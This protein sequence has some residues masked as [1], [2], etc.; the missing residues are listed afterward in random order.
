M[1][2]DKD[3]A[4]VQEVRNLMGAAKAAQKVLAG[5]DQQQID[6]LVAAVAAACEK[7]AEPLA[8]LA[9][10]ETGFGN[11]AD[12]TQKNLLACRTVHDSIKD[13]K[14]IGLIAVDEAQKVEEFAVPIGAIA[15]V[16][17]STNPTSTVMYKALIALKAGNAVVVSPHPAAKNC[18]A[19]TVEIIREAIRKAGG[20]PDAVAAV[21]TPTMEAT[22][23][24]MRHKD[25]GLILATGGPGMV[26]AAY[27]SGNPALGVG[28]GN[29]PAYIER[30][31]NVPAAISR[32]IQSKTFDNGTI[33]ASEQS[34]IVEADMLEGVLTEARRQGVYCMDAKETAKVGGIL[35][36]A[37]GSMSP[38]IVG[39][40]AAQVGEQAGIAV[41]PGTKVL[42]S[43]LQ[44]EVS[45]QN[46]YAREKLCPVLGLF[47]VAN[48]QEAC[49]LCKRLL[50]NEGIGHTMVIHSENL[51]VI[52]QFAAEKPVMRLLV[53]TPGAQGGTGITTNLAPA[54]TLGCGAMGGTATSDNV[55]PMHLL[56]IRRLA[57]GVRDVGPVAEAAAQPA[58]LAAAQAPAVPAAASAA[59]A[60]AAVQSVFAAPAAPV[61][62]ADIESIVNEVIARL[63][64]Q[65][66]GV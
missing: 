16:I 22:D 34:I 51:P 26:K 33:C 40:T 43:C 24:L 27:S 9:V 39:R 50:E 21:T 47:A 53:N 2:L 8:K 61:P 14:T 20:P 19:K 36:R 15:A 62:V 64:Q 31:A 12:K 37:N 17:P 58:A 13:M 18:I 55:T 49:E 4:S 7:Q 11:V 60:Q 54:L 65:C 46:P 63:S 42:L 25:T 48:W 45:K 23:A 30:T 44:A 3:L 5:Y 32:I 1:Q 35:M 66:D 41:P 10:E 38:A 29:G 28:A 57:W 56:N 52:R 59:V 6:A